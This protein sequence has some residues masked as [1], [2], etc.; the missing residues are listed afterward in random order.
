MKLDA[1]GLEVISQAFASVAEEM[2]LVLIYSALSANIRERRDASAALFAADGEMIA[3]A[4]HIPVHLGAL[5]EAVAAVRA[6]EPLPGEM[7]LLNDPYA[8]GSHLPDLTLIGAID[9]EGQIGGYSVVRAHHSDVGGMTAGSMPAGA[10]ELYQEGLIIPP[11]RYTPDL[12]R[13]LLA[14]VRT[15][16]TRRGDLAAQRAAVERGAEGLR[17][18]A[19]RYGW[20][21]LCEAVREL[22][23]YAE[24][25]TKAGLRR[26]PLVQPAT[27]AD[28][29]EGDGITDRDIIIR[30]SLAI[31]DGVLHA[32][33]TGSHGTAAGNVN[34]PLAVT[35]SAVMFVVRTL[36]PEDVPMNGGVA[37]AIR[38]SAPEGCLV[39]ARAPSAVAAGNVETSQ[40]IADTVF[41][42]LAAGGCP[43]PAL[44]QGTMNNVTF[45]SSAWTYYETIGG[46]QGASRGASGPSGAHVGMS[47]TRNTP[48]E[49]LE[50]EHPLRVRT[51]A[52]RRGSGGNGKRTGGDGVVREFEALDE[53]ETTLLTAITA[54]LLGML[55]WGC[56]DFFAKKTIDKIGDLPTLFWGQLLGLI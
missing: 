15:P 52:L 7:F 56:A 12:E 54:G 45:G 40:R 32:D 13:L 49:V 53:M 20:N 34:C 42:A 10:R 37:R 3:Q 1:V 9:I 48:I 24:R 46:G 26:L 11:M 47:N 35:R 38:V 50:M 55:G 43:V 17:W 41:R 30:V 33:F 29:L 19:N 23:D 39:N 16:G 8:G 36:L 25:R 31:N 5:A 27:A 14:N 22:L 2:G 44:G 4:A 28:Y 18:L 6:L 51:Y 21:D